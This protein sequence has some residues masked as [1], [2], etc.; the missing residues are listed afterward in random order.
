MTDFFC[1]NPNANGISASETVYS[2]TWLMPVQIELAM[3]KKYIEF[4]LD[5]KWIRHST[6]FA[7]TPILFVF[8]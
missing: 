2:P 4:F 3:L 6:K 8:K 7:K 1:L 5:K